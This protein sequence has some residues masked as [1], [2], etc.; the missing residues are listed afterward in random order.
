MP[1]EIVAVG[2]GAIASSVWHTEAD[3]TPLIVPV[4]VPPKVLMESFDPLGPQAV[5]MPSST[6]EI[7]SDAEAAKTVVGT[8]ANNARPT[9]RASRCD[10]R[11][12]VS[13]ESKSAENGGSIGWEQVIRFGA[14]YHR[15]RGM[16]RSKLASGAKGR[17][18]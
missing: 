13:S 6:Q 14:G 9:A 10:R 12:S 8:R 7:D 3:H 2:P 4:A 16:P 11:M 15:A 18:S 1:P 5:G 17:D